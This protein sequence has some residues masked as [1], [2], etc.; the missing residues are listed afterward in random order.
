MIPVYSAI[1]YIGLGLAATAM[2]ACWYSSNSFLRIIGVEGVCCVR[3]LWAS[4]HRALLLRICDPYLYEP[5]LPSFSHTG[6][7][8][9]NE[10]R[11]S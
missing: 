3:L 11:L 10:K 7:H 6:K 8:S 5:S 4:C 9:A 1:Y 2:K